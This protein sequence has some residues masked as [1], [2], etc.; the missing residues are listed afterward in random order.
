MCLI[1]K[2]SVLEYLQLNA[3]TGR[4]SSLFHKAIPAK[5]HYSYFQLVV[6]FSR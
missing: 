2:T 1:P 6:Y 5:I 4:K 3:F